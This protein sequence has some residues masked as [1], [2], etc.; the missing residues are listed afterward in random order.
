MLKGYPETAEV[1]SHHHQQDG[2]PE[3]IPFQN[4]PICSH[5]PK[6]SECVTAR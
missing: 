2:Q 5:Q 6:I 4:A 3:G 1:G